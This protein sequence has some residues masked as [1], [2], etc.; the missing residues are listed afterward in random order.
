MNLF[1][2]KGV[3]IIDEEPLKMDDVD[4]RLE[5]FIKIKEDIDPKSEATRIIS[6]YLL[7]GGLWILLS[8]QFVTWIFNDV[9]TIARISTWKGWF[10]VVF[11]GVVFYRIIKRSLNLYQKAVDTIFESY[12]GL[13]FAHKDLVRTEQELQK[14]YRELDESI[15]ISKI[16]EMRFD[17]AVAGANDGIWEWD[18][19]TDHY[20]VS[21]NW[22]LSCGYDRSEIPNTLR[23]WRWMIHPE[24]LE[25]ATKEWKAFVEGGSEALYQSVYRIRCKEGSYRSIL[26]KGVSVRDEKGKILRMAGSH[27][28]ITEQLNLHD[29]LREEQ[30]LNNNIL[31]DSPIMI[32][33]LSPD[34]KIERVNDRAVEMT[35]FLREDVIGQEAFSFVNLEYQDVLFAARARL[36]SGEKVAA[37]EGEIQKKDGTSLYLLWSFSL[38]RDKDQ[39]VRGIILSGTDITDRKIMEQQMYERAYYDSLTGL[40]NRALF[41]ETFRRWLEPGDSEIEDP[42]VLV[43]MDVDQFKHINDIHGHYMGDRMLKYIAEILEETVG[44]EGIVARLGGDEFAIGLHRQRN[45]EVDIL[46]DEIT[47]KLK[48]PWVYEDHQFYIQISSGI[49]CSPDH[50]RDLNT[51]FKRAD[52]ALFAAKDLGRNRVVYFHE[53]MEEKYHEFVLMENMIRNAIE[54]QEFQVHYQPIVNMNTRRIV[55]IEALIRWNQPDKGPVSPVQFIPVAEQTGHIE[56]ITIMVLREAA[57]HRR[58]W[59][60]EGLPVPPIS[61]N[62]SSMHLSQ[63]GWMGSLL[64]V[65]QEDWPEEGS[66]E[67]EITETAILSNEE[68]SME[69]LHRIRE[70]GVSIALDDFGTG[71]SSLTHLQKL[72]IDVLKVDRSFLHHV[73]ED[74]REQSLYKGLVDLAGNLGL[75]VVAEGVETQEQEEFL[76]ENH[77]ELG[78]GY[79]YSKVLP[80][81]ELTLVLKEGQV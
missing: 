5:Y 72:P 66:L 38:L 32:L 25:K 45:Q 48:K 14:R 15:K 16:N 3:A 36:E 13:S 52:V 59:K 11:T 22:L 68:H 73:L 43:S 60:E 30:E 58:T 61:I 65:I 7:L 70:C 8:D 17:L 6:L 33:L 80:A 81:N 10:Y 57:R 75:D 20:R 9:E 79:Y 53:S 12:K 54:R 51:L 67:L 69:L 2:M 23:Q 29:T 21:E 35:G 24:D 56:E 37:M 63:E 4:K 62:L 40:P 71:Y 47:E 49:V 44:R 27:T 1:R 76:L 42:L 31:E 74:Q 41:M 64:Q 34:W 18:G 28:D 26:S 39:L 19:R 55:K 46:M 78:Q 77:C 50:G